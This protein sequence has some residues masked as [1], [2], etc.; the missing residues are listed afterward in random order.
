MGISMNLRFPLCNLIA[1]GHLPLANKTA[2][3]NFAKS[4][5]EGTATRICFEMLKLDNLKESA[6]LLEQAQNVFLMESGNSV[7]TSISND[8]AFRHQRDAILLREDSNDRQNQP[9]NIDQTRQFV[10]MIKT[11]GWV[12]ALGWL[13][14][15]TK[16]QKEEIMR[17]LKQV[18]PTTYNT[19]QNNWIGS[20]LG[21]PDDNGKFFKRLAKAG[22]GMKYAPGGERGLAPSDARRLKNY[23]Y[24]KMKKAGIATLIAGGIATALVSISLLYKRYFSAAAKE[25]KNLSGKQ[26]TVCM[27]K[28]R[29]KAAEAAIKE[30]EKGLLE[31][32]SAKNEEDCIFKMKV[33]IRSWKKKKMAEEEKLRKLTN[34]NKAAFGEDEDKHSNDPFA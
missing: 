9:V 31:C 29:I 30:A 27:T 10:N 25:C 22:I 18:Y 8:A 26:R 34:V 21:M 23:F 7:S 13:A 5:D 12:V 24:P 32:S 16:E 28:A 4:L 17:S 15:R 11:G 33:E 14:S 2:S 1:R 20:K 6:T 19:L 3:L